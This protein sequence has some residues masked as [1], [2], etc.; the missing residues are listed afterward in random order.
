MILNIFTKFNYIDIEVFGYV[1][2]YGLLIIIPLEL[3][4]GIIQYNNYDKNKRTQRQIMEQVERMNNNINRIYS[5]LKGL[6]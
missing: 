2:F 6:E 4:D 1:M 5:K 3:L